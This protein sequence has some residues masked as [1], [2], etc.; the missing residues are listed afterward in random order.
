M[1]GGPLYCVLRFLHTRASSPLSAAGA[2]EA[3]TE[4]AIKN[5]AMEKDL[6]GEI[7]KERAKLKVAHV[8]FVKVENSSSAPRRRKNRL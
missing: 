6:M 1:A 7:Y 5:P 8:T 3:A 4:S 2:G